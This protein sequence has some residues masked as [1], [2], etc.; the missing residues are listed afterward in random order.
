MY[1]E[2]E[3]ELNELTEDVSQIQEDIQYAK[4][5]LE[6]LRS[7]EISGIK[8]NVLIEGC[9]DNYKHVKIF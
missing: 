7:G 1:D 4:K 2:I 6:R 5:Q 8:Y 9:L 3:N